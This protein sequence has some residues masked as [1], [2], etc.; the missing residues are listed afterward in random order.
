MLTVSYLFE[1]SMKTLSALSVSS[2]FWPFLV[3]SGRLASLLLGWALSSARKAWSCWVQNA[4]SCSRRL[5]RWR[6]CG[7][8]PSRRNGCSWWSSSHGR[9]SDGLKSSGIPW[10]L[11][12]YVWK[13]CDHSNLLKTFELNLWLVHTISEKSWYGRRFQR[14]HK[15]SPKGRESGTLAKTN[16]SLKKSGQ[17]SSGFWWTS[18]K[19]RGMFAANEATS[20]SWRNP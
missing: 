5:E 2:H 10:E 11:L 16:T 17:N 8:R 9:C 12:D 18:W 14:L 20:C 4:S 15:G 7:G 19:I 1:D 6:C 3:I 13:S